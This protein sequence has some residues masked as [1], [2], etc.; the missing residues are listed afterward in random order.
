VDVA[1][2]VDAFEADLAKIGATATM[3][4]I[5]FFG[6]SAIAATAG[7]VKSPVK[8]IP[9]AIFLSVAIVTV[10][11]TFVV[12]VVVAAG[13]DEYTEAA[14]GTAAR[15]FLG[16][17]GGLVIVGG[18][19]FSMVSASNASIMAGS[20]VVMAMSRLGHLP[21]RMGAVHQRTR[22]PI[23]ALA[24]VGL[25]ILGFL[26]LLPLEDLAHF[27]DTV[28]LVA[29][30]LVNAA[31]IVSRR[32]FPNLVRPFRVPLVPVLPALGMVANVYLI[33]Q[34]S[35]HVVPLALAFGSVAV[36]L[37]GYA[38]WRSP[39]LERAPVAVRPSVPAPEP[40]PERP[41]FR[42]LVPVAHPGH[43]NFLID[44]AAAVA[45]DQDGELV[46]LRVVE[47][48]EQDVPR[49]DHEEVAR[50]REI[51]DTA[52]R[53]ARQH[54][55]VV[56]SIVRLAHDVADA[57]LET[58]SE[59]LCDLVVL[60]WKGH[61]TTAGR[62]LGDVTDQVVRHAGCDVMLVK[63]V[64]SRLPESMLLPTAGGPH[65]QR[66]EYYAAS[67]THAQGGTLAIS[68]VLAPAA[69]AEHMSRAQ[70]SVN[71]A[72]DRIGALDGVSAQLI[73]HESVETGI[74]EAAS[75]YDA[76]VV[77]A[78]GDPFSKQLLFGNIPERVAR[79]SD[80]TVIMVKRH[81]DVTPRRPSWQVEGERAAEP[82]AEE[83]VAPEAPVQ[84]QDEDAGADGEPTA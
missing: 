84:A 83:A 73:R 26:L 36:G 49:L 28:L 39:A 16:P 48:P 66:A 67:I 57:V 32:K 46:V 80:R 25:A 14:M 77:G 10:L 75:E 7:E 22:T 78:A 62:I 71:A 81:P 76:V 3:V 37:V 55:L 53:R 61:T 59:R 31:L 82:S 54:G 9:R 69:P 65:A 17:V 43:V 2:F 5:T 58:A 60:G 4:F 45:R 30:T 79:N 70:R 29:L 11:Y 15:Q 8:T 56:T 6:F 63:P 72:V 42:V 44:L 12:L 24:L 34:I 38:L 23:L 74:L 21:R 40:A 47:V 41:P 13:L 19:L 51:L 20:R 27:A 64:G 68:S 52:R 35:H 1:S 50:Q 33:V 18:A